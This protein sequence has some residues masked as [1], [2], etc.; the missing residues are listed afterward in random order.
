MDTSKADEFVWNVAL[1]L[2]ISECSY[3]N[4]I[5]NRP[6]PKSVP[7]TFQEASR[8]PMVDSL[9]IDTYGMLDFGLDYD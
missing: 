7:T 5:L 6:K 4:F 8:S 3:Y 2:S 9:E 1:C